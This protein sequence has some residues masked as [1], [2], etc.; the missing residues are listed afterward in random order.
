MMRQPYSENKGD[1]ARTS[2][3]MRKRNGV[4]KWNGEA[5]TGSGQR[6]GTR[7][8]F[9]ATVREGLGDQDSITV[10]AQAPLTSPE[11][12]S[13]AQRRLT[14]PKIKKPLQGRVKPCNGFLLALPSGY[15][16]RSQSSMTSIR[17]NVSGREQNI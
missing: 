1:E 2:L 9:C 16:K 14:P 5:V 12:R 13:Q 8:H 10:I 11:P 15:A 17:P 7:W 3:L 4:G 6:S